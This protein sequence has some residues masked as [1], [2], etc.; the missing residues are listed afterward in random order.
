[1]DFLK[2]LYHAHIW[3]VA[4]ASHWYQPDGTPDYRAWL[5]AMLYLRLD[6][7]IA[8]L[9]RTMPDD[10]APLFGR[11]A[12]NYLTALH[13]SVTI[14]QAS[15]FSF[16]KAL[17]LLNPYLKSTKISW[18]INPIPHHIKIAL[19]ETHEFPHCGLPPCH[20]NEWDPSILKKRLQKM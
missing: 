17:L 1:M 19:Q 14:S 6:I 8:E 13:S 11:D 16:D 4:S 18:I 20:K 12:V 2:N 5:R 15:V 7:R 3:H 9:Y 10:H